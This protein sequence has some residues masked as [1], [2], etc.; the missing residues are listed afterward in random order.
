M[1]LGVSAQPFSFARFPKNR[2]SEYLRPFSILV[3]LLSFELPWRNL[4]WRSTQAD[5]E[6]SEGKKDGLPVGLGKDEEL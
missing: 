5:E 3:D 2:T 6:G 1:V 4:F